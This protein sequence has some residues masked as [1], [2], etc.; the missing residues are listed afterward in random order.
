MEQTDY[1]F[2]PPQNPGYYPPTMGT[3]Q[4]QALGTK[5][6]LQ[7]QALFRRYIAV[8]GA[9]RHST[10]TSISA[11]TGGPV[12]RIW[13]GFHNLYVKSSFYLL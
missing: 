2:V 12:K 10:P 7:N 1:A 6:F 3:A 4:E 8:G 13:T 9:D 11:P 5:S